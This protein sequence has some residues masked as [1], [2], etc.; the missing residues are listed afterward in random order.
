M[1][2]STDVDVHMEQMGGKRA[3]SPMLFVRV[4][5][6]CAICIYL[7]LFVHFVPFQPLHNLYRLMRWIHKD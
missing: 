2:E 6:C 4:R 1:V 5:S 3:L 7:I